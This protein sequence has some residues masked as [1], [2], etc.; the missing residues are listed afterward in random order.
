MFR[1][2]SHEIKELEFLHTAFS[3]NNYYGGVICCYTPL[4]FIHSRNSDYPCLPWQ[5][6]SIEEP[7]RRKVNTSLTAGA[8][9]KGQNQLSHMSGLILFP[10]EVEFGVLKEGCTYCYTVYLKNTGI[11][12]CRFRIKQPPPATGLRIIYNPGPVCV[13]L[14]TYILDFTMNT[15][16]YRRCLMLE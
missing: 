8:S 12:S 7:V 1:L 9:I 11:D 3:V 6:I 2:H 16:D 14:I 15:F 4:R 5:Y 10:E 13:D